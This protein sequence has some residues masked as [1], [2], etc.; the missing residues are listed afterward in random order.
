MAKTNDDS[1]DFFPLSDND[2]LQRWTVG[3][4]DRLH[5]LIG[6]GNQWQTS[7]RRAEL[8]KIEDAD[9]EKL[10]NIAEGMEGEGN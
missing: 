4:L 2:I 10:H 6:L 1:L 9:L 5:D 7:D 3:E 8:K